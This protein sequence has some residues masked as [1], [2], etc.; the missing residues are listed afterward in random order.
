MKSAHELQAIVD[1]AAQDFRKQIVEVV[2]EVAKNLDLPQKKR[3]AKCMEEISVL[4]RQSFQQ[5]AEESSL[6][7]PLS[8]SRDLAALLTAERKLPVPRVTLIQIDGPL[9]GRQFVFDKP[10][11][12]VLGRDEGCLPRFPP[13]KPTKPSPGTIASSTSI[14]RTFAFATWAV[15]AEPMSMTS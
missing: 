9:K 13:R 5:A 11:S 8:D 6:A 14:R 10:G 15:Q 3:L 4:L 12:T 1:M 7:V 2:R